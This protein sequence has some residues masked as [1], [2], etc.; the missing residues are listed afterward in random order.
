MENNIEQASNTESSAQNERL[1]RQQELNEIVGRAKHEAV[2]SFKRQQAQQT[3]NSGLSESDIKRLASEEIARQRDAWA[4]E[5]QEQAEAEAAARIVQAYKEKISAGRDK[6]EDFDSVTKTLDMRG[7]P[8]A[9]Q[10]LA[11]HVD[12]ASDVLYEFAKNRTRLNQIESIA[13]RN[14]RDAIYEVKRLA[15]SIKANEKTTQMKTVNTP[16]SQQ[17]PS[18]TGTDS[19]S[20]RP[21][22]RDLRARYRG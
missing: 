8:N 22:M 10:L 12:N 5:V 6:Y 13:E 3:Q 15:D 18:T 14:P 17:R 20:A 2:E 21:S 9:V 11:E 16:L 19:G 7:Y 1:F 4:K